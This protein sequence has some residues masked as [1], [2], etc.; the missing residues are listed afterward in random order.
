[1]K[2]VLANKLSDMTGYST[3]ALDDKRLKGIWLEDVMWKKAP[4]G[5]VVYNTEA[6]EKWAEGFEQHQIQV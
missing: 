2:W 3:R 1:M 5:R 6:Y 4:D